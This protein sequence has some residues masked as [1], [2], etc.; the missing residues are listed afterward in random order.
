MEDIVAKAS[1]MELVPKSPGYHKDHLAEEGA[2]E[3]V[4]NDPKELSTGEQPDVV[5]QLDI[6]PSVLDKGAPAV[7]QGGDG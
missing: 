3:T 6:A 5:K 1:R 4:P 2:G 7:Q